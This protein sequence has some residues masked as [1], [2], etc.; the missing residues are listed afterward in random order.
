MKSF[1]STHSY[2]MVKMFLNQFAI[3]VFGF[4]LVL[5]SGKADNVVLRNVTSAFS[6]LFYLFLL[7]VMTWEIGFRDKVSVETGRKKRN[8]FT[9]ALISLCANSINFILAIFITL[10]SLFNVE[11]LSNIGG[12]CAS[13]A[14]FIEG[15]Y[16]GLLTNHLWGAP[17]NS[18]AWVYFLLPLPAIL[19]CGLSYYLGLRD[20]KFT[21]L[22]NQVYPESD[23]EPTKKEKRNRD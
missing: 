15:M 6:I 21:S 3:A 2:N 19:T 1:F 17:L 12:I 10:A 23:R 22:F 16:A 18:Y 9:G 13:V 8:P 14:I 5:A 7:Y 4:V 20:I 11:A